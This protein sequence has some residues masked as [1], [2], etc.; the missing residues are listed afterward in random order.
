MT[1]IS[2]LYY[3]HFQD[4][5]GRCCLGNLI[6]NGFCWSNLGSLLRIGVVWAILPC[7]NS[8]LSSSQILD[9][10]SISEMTNYSYAISLLL[11][12][13][14]LFVFLIFQFSLFGLLIWS[15]VKQ[16]WN[17]IHSIPSKVK[18]FIDFSY[19]Q[20]LLVDRNVRFD[21]CL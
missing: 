14:G 18:I 15:R 8:Y 17:T 9:Y 13:I 5:V 7:S 20:Y 4:M 10:S 6:I 21:L 2:D 3:G 16:S 19:Y 11:F 12:R 1:T